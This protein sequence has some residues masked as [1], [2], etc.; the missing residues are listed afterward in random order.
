[1]KDRET[2]RSRGFG[3][4][5]FSSPDVRS[6]TIMPLP[7]IIFIRRQTLQSQPSMARI[8]MAETSGPFLHHQ[9]SVSISLL[10]LF[11]VNL[12]N[13]RPPGGGGGGRGG[14]GG[15]G[16]GGGGGGGSRW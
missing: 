8:S 2:G 5:T 9:L 14:G 13:D 15:Y 16:R 1:M 7:P 3:F 6:F 12:A 11:S 10:P 4:V